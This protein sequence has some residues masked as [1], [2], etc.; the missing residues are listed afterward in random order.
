VKLALVETHQRGRPP[1][2]PTAYIRAAVIPRADM[3]GGPI[4]QTFRSDDPADAV[5]GM[6]SAGRG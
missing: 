3:I 5:K 1:L 6:R 2:R 4:L